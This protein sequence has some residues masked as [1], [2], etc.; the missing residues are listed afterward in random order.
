MSL[1]RSKQTS[2][3]PYTICPTISR[4]RLKTTWW[5][6]ERRR[7]QSGSSCCPPAPEAG[8]R[9]NACWC[10][11]HN[12][13]G[14]LKKSL[15]RLTAKLFEAFRLSRNSE[16]M[17]W[18]HVLAERNSPYKRQRGHP[19]VSYTMSSCLA[20]YVLSTSTSNKVSC[21]I[22]G[23][24]GIRTLAPVFPTYT[25]SRGAPSANLGTSP[26]SLRLFLCS[27]ITQWSTTIV[28]IQLF[29]N[30]LARPKAC[31]GG[32]RGIRTPGALLRHH[33]F[34]RPAP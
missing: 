9:P 18:R 17:V 23:E 32:E 10:W 28:C 7:A 30:G 16:D 14:A 1:Q 13:K 22:G 29:E 2:P 5:H 21:F 31:N 6:G 33:W 20:T 34:S 8:M 12:K 15:E 25:L 4:K 3:I 19:I 27:L 11:R 26:S 24:G